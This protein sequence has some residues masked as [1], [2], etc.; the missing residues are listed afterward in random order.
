[1]TARLRSWCHDCN[2]LVYYID[3]LRYDAAND[4]AIMPN[5]VELSRKSIAFRDALTTA[6]DTRHALAAL[7]SG[8][9]DLDNANGNGLLALSRKVGMK[10][11]LVIPRSALD[12]LAKERP[13]FAF[14][15]TIAIPDYSPDRL[16][17]WGYGA[18]QATAEPIV[19][20]AVDWL[21]THGSE[22]FFLWLYHYDVHN[23]RDLD[24]DFAEKHAAELH[25]PQE[26][27]LN[28][29]YRVAA[30]GVDAA[31]GRLMTTLER[32]KL[33][34]RTIIIVLSDHGEGLG[35]AGFWVHSTFIWQSLVHVPL[36]IRIPCLS[37]QNIADR[38]SLVDIAPTLARYLDPAADLS[39][40]HGEDLAGWIATGRHERRLPILLLGA[41][42][43]EILHLGLVEPS[44]P[45]K[46]DLPLDTGV[47]EL[48][49]L[50]LDEPD[51]IDFAENERAKMLSMLRELVNA[52]TF[53][54]ARLA[55]GQ[56]RHGEC[57]AQGLREG[58][59]ASSRCSSVRDR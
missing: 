44:G 12:Y 52:P 50:R 27:E 22:R 3:T 54:S 24:G 17:V 53:S 31:L 21:E 18:D 36:I 59:P 37:P 20:A 19:D 9:Y 38:V 14:D 34:D 2:V 39:V 49:D 25:L 48:Y 46:V 33:A 23:W 1:M 16:D 47:P 4:P 13:E 56:A 5:L 57:D 42:R 51:D 58:S 28:W 43:H 6:S 55:R 10:Q 11:T 15:Q 30:A 45:W 26:A 8:T 41:R 32:M 7:L 35:E 29:K 40:Y